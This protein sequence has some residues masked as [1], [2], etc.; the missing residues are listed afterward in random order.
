MNLSKSFNFYA[1]ISL[2]VV[3]AGCASSSS[4]NV[5]GDSLVASNLSIDSVTVTNSTGENF[6]G[7]D[8]IA[9]MRS[10]TEDQ[11]MK[12]NLKQPMSG[13]SYNL[14]IDIVQYSKGNAVARW[15]LPG[16]G[17]TILS[18]EARLKNDVGAIVAESQATESIGAGGLYTIG[19]WKR[20]FDK[21]ANSLVTDIANLISR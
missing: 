15:M 12:K 9:L 21:V 3:L 19:A 20:V 13:T 18:V 1:S 7:A 17:K 14:E 4:I 6:D 16:A 11:V 5:V 8:V 2:L 10:A